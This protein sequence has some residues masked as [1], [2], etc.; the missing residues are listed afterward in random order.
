MCRVAP[1]VARGLGDDVYTVLQREGEG[2]AQAD[3][4][5]RV[6]VRLIYQLQGFLRFRKR[7]SHPVVSRRKHQNGVIL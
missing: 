6:K 3:G 4:L 1:F 5:H 7:Y 2:T